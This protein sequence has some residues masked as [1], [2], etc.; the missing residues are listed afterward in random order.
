MEQQ[1]GLRWV[2]GTWVRGLRS[3]G[4]TCIGLALGAAF[5][6][7][8]HAASSTASSTATVVTPITVSV[9]ET[10]RSSDRRWT[11]TAGDALTYSLLS[12]ILGN[13]VA[14]GTLVTGTQTMLLNGMDA[15]SVHSIT[16]AYD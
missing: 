2:A 12:P 7:S 14:D 5:G 16:V 6:T 11:V 1:V 13:S 15:E 3:T 10:P 4:M 8:V 9:N